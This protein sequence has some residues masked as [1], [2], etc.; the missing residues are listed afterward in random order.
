VSE[1]GRSELRLRVRVIDD[2]IIVSLPGSSYGVTYKL[3][4]PPRLVAKTT[5]LR[6]DP[7]YAMSRSDFLVKASKL[8]KDKARELGWSV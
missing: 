6:D 5:P 2:E 3:G 4:S 7:R 1:M 8:A